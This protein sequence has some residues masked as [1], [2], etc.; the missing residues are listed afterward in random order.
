MEFGRVRGNSG[1]S[2]E[3][4]G[5]SVEFSGVFYGALCEF[6]GDFGATQKIWGLGWFCTLLSKERVNQ[7]TQ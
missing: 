5:N 4:Q 2:R 3:T 7:R 6:S 1:N